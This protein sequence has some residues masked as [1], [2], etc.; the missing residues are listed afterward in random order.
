MGGDPIPSPLDI[1]RDWYQL[2]NL[3]GEAKTKTLKRIEDWLEK[4]T[5]GNKRKSDS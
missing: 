5:H 2:P 1:L 3:E 4:R